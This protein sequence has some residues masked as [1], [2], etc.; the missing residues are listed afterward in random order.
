MPHRAESLSTKRPKNPSSFALAATIAIVLSGTLPSHAA[1]VSPVGR[2]VTYSDR[3][4]KPTGVIEI[5]LDHGA[6]QGTILQQLNRSASLPPAICAACDGAR[7]NAPIVGM[8]IMWGLTKSS[9]A[10]WDD[11][12]ILDPDSGDVYSA[13]VEL[14]DGGQKL[15]VRG[16]LGISLLGRSQ[17]WIRQN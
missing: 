2:W 3:T 4:H 5:K 14:E 17:E 16:Y 13:K 10:A 15:L 1:D 8:T 7:K 12:S 6:L 9:A 11:G